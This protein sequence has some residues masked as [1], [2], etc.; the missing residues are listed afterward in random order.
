MRMGKS[1]RTK[2]TTFKPETRER[3]IER[4]TGCIFCRAN[5]CM[6]KKKGWEETIFDIA[7]IV[8]RSQGGLGVEQNGVLACRYHHGLLDNGNKGYRE[9][10]LRF[11]EDYLK[12]IYPDWNR[13]ELVYHKWK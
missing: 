10:F 5:L 7:H 12:S 2:A 13:E 3:I 9:E 4:D 8:N 6:P 1:R 11:A